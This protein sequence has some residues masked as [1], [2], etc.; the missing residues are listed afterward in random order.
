[1]HCETVLKLV[2]SWC[3]TCLATLDKPRAQPRSIKDAIVDAPGCPH[4][5]AAPCVQPEADTLAGPHTN[6]R[7]CTAACRSWSSLCSCSC[8]F[9]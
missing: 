3:F 2:S 8:A 6:A 7:A 1:M 5:L 9:G 4:S